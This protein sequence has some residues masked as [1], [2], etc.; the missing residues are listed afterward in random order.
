MDTP[1][2]TSATDAEFVTEGLKRGIFTKITMTLVG[3]MYDLEVSK[4]LSLGA[5]FVGPLDREKRSDTLL[6]GA[7]VFVLTYEEPDDPRESIGYSR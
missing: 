5:R 3:N 1:S 6:R 7:E 4:L 2:L